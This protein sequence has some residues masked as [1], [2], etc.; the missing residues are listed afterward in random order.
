MSEGDGIKKFIIFI[1]EWERSQELREHIALAENIV[2][3]R[4]WTSNTAV[5]TE[6]RVEGIQYYA[7]REGMM[8]CVDLNE[9]EARESVILS[10]ASPSLMRNDEYCRTLVKS[11]SRGCSVI[12]SNLPIDCN[13]LI[14]VVAESNDPDT[15]LSNLHIS[16]CCNKE[17]AI[18]D[19]AVIMK[20]LGKINVIKFVMNL[21]PPGWG[22]NEDNPFI[23]ADYLNNAVL[24][25]RFLLQG[26]N[27]VSAIGPKVE[28][29]AFTSLITFKKD[30]IVTNVNLQIFT[31][32]RIEDRHF[33]IYI[34]GAYGN[35]EAVLRGGKWSIQRSL[36]KQYEF[37]WIIP[38]D[39]LYRALLDIKSFD[40]KIGVCKMFEINQWV[41][42]LLQND[43]RKIVFKL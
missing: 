31:E 25:L 6:N 1:D 26:A 13:N 32:K 12:L 9:E 19:L 11:A 36:G 7:G 39:G 35:V 20:D 37:P 14:R 40:D 27:V 5:T 34:N 16:A 28:S 24:V 22:S 29:N 17:K 23:M 2:V 42:S 43:G 10:C 3:T 15:V 18:N 30:D 38:S 33:K 21:V 4:L 41:S 8:N